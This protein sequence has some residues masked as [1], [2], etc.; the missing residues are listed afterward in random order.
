MLQHTHASRKVLYSV[1]WYKAKAKGPC[2]GELVGYDAFS[3]VVREGGKK[4]RRSV[5]K[6]NTTQGQS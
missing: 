5:A 1:L 4:R 6:T 3:L 2:V